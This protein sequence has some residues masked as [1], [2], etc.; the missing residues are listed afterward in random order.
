MPPQDAIVPP[1]LKEKIKK[2]LTI[3]DLAHKMQNI[4][5]TLEERKEI[6]E[7]VRTYFSIETWQENLNRIFSEMKKST[8][9]KKTALF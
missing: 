5:M 9:A 4:T 2:S 6:A 7:E 8:K 3:E 1:A